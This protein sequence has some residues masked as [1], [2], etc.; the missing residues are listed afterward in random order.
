[1][2]R[3]IGVV[4]TIRISN[5]MTEIKANIE[6]EFVEG[7]SYFSFITHSRILD[8]ERLGKIL[9]VI[10]FSSSLLEC[11]LLWLHSLHVVKTIY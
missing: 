2:I 11:R 10:S 7:I 5:I 6:E 1:M 8:I 4:K 3:H 9:F